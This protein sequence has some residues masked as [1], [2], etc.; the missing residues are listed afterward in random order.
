M[1]GYVGPR[2]LLESLD[3]REEFASPGIKPGRHGLPTGRLVSSLA[4]ILGPRTLSDGVTFVNDIYYY[5]FK[6]HLFRPCCSVLVLVR[7]TLRICCSFP[8]KD[9]SNIVLHAPACNET[10]SRIPG[11]LRTDGICP[12]YN[13][14]FTLSDAET[15]ETCSPC[16]FDEFQ[17]NELYSEQQKVP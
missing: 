15:E 12:Q 2:V 1:G 4:T 5:L 7:T 16:L 10:I 11:V 8:R 17:G 9:C 6:F 14:I 13:Q 3:K